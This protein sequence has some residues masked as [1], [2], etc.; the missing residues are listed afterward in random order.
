VALGDTFVGTAGDVVVIGRLFFIGL[1]IGHGVGPELSVLV[2]GIRT[3]RT[4]GK[5]RDGTVHHVAAHFHL[6]LLEQSCIGAVERTKIEGAS[7]VVLPKLAFFD[8]V[9]GFVSGD[10]GVT[11]VC[12][13]ERVRTPGGVGH[14]VVIVRNVKVSGQKNLLHVTEAAG[15]LALFLGFGER[16]EEHAGEDGNDRDDDQQFNERETAWR[17]TRPGRVFHKR[18]AVTGFVGMIAEMR[19]QCPYGKSTR[20]NDLFRRAGCLPLTETIGRRIG[21]NSEHMK[22]RIFLLILLFH[23][24]PV[25]FGCLW[26]HNTKMNGGTISVNGLNPVFSLRVAMKAEKGSW[27]AEEKRLR[28]TWH[29]MDFETQS[30]YAVALLHLGRVDEGLEILKK[31]SEK[32]A[33]D[34]VV[35]ANLGTAYEL[36]GKPV[37]ALQWI[38]RALDLNETSHYGTE[39][40]HVQIL[41]AEIELAKN[42]NWLKGHSVL[43]LDFG[44]EPK[45]KELADLKD[46]KVVKRLEGALRY[47]L[48][49]RVQLVEKPNAIVADL[50]FDWGNIIAMSQGLEHAL[51][52]YDLSLEFGDVRKAIIE[53]RRVEF[54]RIIWRAAPF[55]FARKHVEE[56]VISGVV[57][58]LVGLV[59]FRNRKGKRRALSVAIL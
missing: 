31:I 52:M 25:G 44:N 3:A 56:I 41:N 20:N 7:A 36:Q 45:P 22:S 47:Q 59:V 51:S 4:G 32:H 40:L 15:T 24:L 46:P 11:P 1:P 53:S 14:V 18:V 43:G 38:K 21:R 27:E 42:A 26:S 9:I 8:G 17:V 10:A 16:R 29:L 23:G 30:D 33:Q 39:W 35:A 12:D 55:R 49:E 34:Y 37:E 6:T 54:E 13:I 57:L 50:L 19:R 5:F 2:G 58:A 48:T 28:P